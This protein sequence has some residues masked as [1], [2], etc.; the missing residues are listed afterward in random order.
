[1]CGLFD[2]PEPQA[3]PPP[4]KQ[5]PLVAANSDTSSTSKS[6]RQ[7]LSALTVELAAGDTKSGLQI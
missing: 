3:P 5:A 1:M 4:K 7:G 6:K 2:P